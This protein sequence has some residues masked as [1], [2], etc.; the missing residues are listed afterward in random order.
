MNGGFVPLILQLGQA[1]PELLKKLLAWHAKLPATLRGTSRELRGAVNK[2]VWVVKLSLSNTGNVGRNAVDV[3]SELATTFTNARS[4]IPDFSHA[5]AT[6]EVIM[7]LKRLK[8]QSP[9]FLGNL[10]SLDVT[11]KPDQACGALGS[12]ALVEF[13]QR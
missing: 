6:A 5:N 13:M 7:V 4:L 2:T 11:I 8:D 1:A 12:A 10:Q 9:K 3:T